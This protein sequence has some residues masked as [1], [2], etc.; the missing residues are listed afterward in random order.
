MWFSYERPRESP[1]PSKFTER[2]VPEK[3][4]RPILKEKGMKHKQP[5]NDSW[6][7]SQKKLVSVHFVNGKTTNIYCDSWV[8]HQDEFC[9]NVIFNGTDGQVHINYNNV[10][11]IQ[12]CMF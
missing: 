10:T 4:E 12:E 9:R 11:Y 3:G 8:V 1:G 5:S 2:P 6:P 7:Y